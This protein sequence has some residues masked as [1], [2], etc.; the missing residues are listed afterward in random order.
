[1]VSFF[2]RISCCLFF[3]WLIHQWICL[4]EI[5]NVHSVIQWMGN[6]AEAMIVYSESRCG[7]Q[8]IRKGVNGLATVLSLIN[9][10]IS[11]FCAA[12]EQIGR[13]RCE[14]SRHVANRIINKSKER[15]FD[16]RELLLCGGIS[17]FNYNVEYWIYRCYSDG[18]VSYIKY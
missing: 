12:S 10:L 14:F 5:I 4:E 17:L 6:H 1:M 8:T 2:L 16:W 7:N 15:R 11:K 3:M 13:K 9:L 18:V